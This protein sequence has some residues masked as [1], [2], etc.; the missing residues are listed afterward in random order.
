MCLKPSWQRCTLSPALLIPCR[1]TNVYC[2]DMRTGMCHSD[3]NPS[4][5]R[6]LPSGVLSNLAAG[7]S[8]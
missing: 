4:Q 7:H 1:A 8:E 3:R 6:S 5:S 2:S